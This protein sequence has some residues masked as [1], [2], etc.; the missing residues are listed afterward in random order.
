M[1][2]RPTPPDRPAP[3]TVARLVALEAQR[4]GLA[5]LLGGAAAAAGATGAPDVA[6][7]VLSTDTAADPS[8]AGVAAPRSDVAAPSP[9]HES[10]MRASGSVALPI[11]RS[12]LAER[13]AAALDP[14]AAPATRAADVAVRLDPAAW[15]PALHQ[16]LLVRLHAHH[17]A[18][19]RGL[20]HPVHPATARQLRA[21][22]RWL[23]ERT[24]VATG[25]PELVRLARALRLDRRLVRVAAAAVA[26]AAV[27]LALGC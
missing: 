27:V 25:D 18:V 24:E 4:P 3:A 1:P 12:E 21:L 8:P 14:L 7:A 15:I 17:A 26:A 11:A 2:A 23:A 20:P 19:A 10:T 22:A 9:A 6:N 13:A 5:V 16:P